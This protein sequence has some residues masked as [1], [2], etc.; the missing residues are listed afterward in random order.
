MDDRVQNTDVYST[1]ERSITAIL[2]DVVANIQEIIRYE[3][4]LAKT[5][6][7]EEGSRASKAAALMTGGAVFA[8]F[9]LEFV[10]FCVVFALAL[11][12]PLWLSSLLVGVALF[13]AAAILLSSGRERWRRIHPGEQTIDSVKENLEWARQQNR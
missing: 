8:L 7:R 12:L 6:L 4:R 2:K 13:L 10:F 1:D 11:V 3:V 5:E 9:A